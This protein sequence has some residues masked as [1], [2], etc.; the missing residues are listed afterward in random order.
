[1]NYLLFISLLITLFHHK[2][3]LIAILIFSQ[4]TGACHP[5]SRM[6]KRKPTLIKRV[7]DIKG[8]AVGAIVGCAAGGMLNGVGTSLESYAMYRN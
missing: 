6:S 4:Q 5:K 3:T 7:G 2:M 1:V 8:A